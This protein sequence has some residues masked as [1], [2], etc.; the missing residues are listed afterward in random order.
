MRHRAR[1]RPVRSFVLLV[2]VALGALQAPARGGLVLVDVLDCSSSRSRVRHSVRFSLGSI[3]SETATVGRLTLPVA[4]VM[5]QPGGAFAARMGRASSG[6]ARRLLAI[7]L[8]TA[9]QHQGRRQAFAVYLGGV[10]AY[11]S[12][13][14]DPGAGVTRTCFVEAGDGS[15]VLDV[16]IVADRS[17]TAPL[18]VAMLR[19]YRDSP[20]EPAEDRDPVVRMGL[21]LLTSRGLGYSIDEAELRRIGALIP[22]SRYLTPQAA[23]LYNFCVRNPAQNAAEIR[24]LADLARHAGIPLR[25]AFQVHWSGIPAGVPD[26]AGGTFTDLPYQQI[27]YDPDEQ[28]EKPGLAALMGPA[29]DPHYGLTV[30]N[31]WGNTPWLT[32]NHPRLNQYRRL[33][34]KQAIGAW[35]AERDRLRAGG[36]QDLLPGELSTGDETVYWAKGVDD[37]GYTAFNGGKPRTHLMADF[38]P[39]TVAAAARDGVTLDPRHGL[40][41][42]QRMWLHQNL[43][44]WQQTLVN[45]IREGLPP[46]PVQLSEGEPAYA[47][48]LVARNVYTEPYAMPVYPMKG[49]NSLHPGLEVGYVLNGRSGGE[50][51][52]GAAML[53]WLIKERERGRIALPNL[54]CTGADDGQLVACL[55]A[56]YAYGARFVT[57]YNW[58]YRQNVSDLLA[59]FVRSVARPAGLAFE[60]GAPEPPRSEA[61]LLSRE[62]AAPPDAFGVN[63]VEVAV[64]P[65]RRKRMELRVSLREVGPDHPEAVSVTSSIA[66]RGPD[67]GQWVQVSLPCMFHQSPGRRYEVSAEALGEGGGT[68][69]A[70]QD[71]ALAVRLLADLAEERARSVA[72]E[73]RQDAIDVIESVA[74]RHRAYPPAEPVAAMLLDARRLLARG[75]VRE[76]YRAAIR[77]DQ[78][79]VPA[80]Y[81]VP[82]PGARL[83]PYDLAVECPLA[84][85]RAVVRDYTAG[86]ARVVIRSPRA[87][88]VAL[89]RGAV[90]TTA[91]VAPNIDVQLW[92]E[93]RPARAG[94]GGVASSGAHR[95]R[96]RRHARVRSTA[97]KQAER[98]SAQPSAPRLRR[99]AALRY[100]GRAKRP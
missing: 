7:T 16:R 37:S 2:L 19:I 9:P 61:A 10:E 31:R 67:A 80:A 64:R 38:N 63:R 90:R 91:T 92:V 8:A 69:E 87:Q 52:S 4:G 24:R 23:V 58:H 56:A 62:Y 88:V 76:A 40:D 43:A 81:E 74:K 98:R 48:D 11:R 44:W 20:G 34:L 68:V 17:T 26:G 51:W 32:M 42:T 47:E 39:F 65:G 29:Y 85:V 54:E 15:D 96:L 71:G 1:C 77:A 97:G 89:K 30:P 41:V 27:T 45:W 50:Y 13:E 36:L 86:L 75:A 3:R 94:A 33:R 14:T 35:Q 6:G 99:G 95:P 66:V 84:P 93:R 60:P 25:V 46:E 72:L 28:A 83:T 12:V 21:A 18:T 55:R 82:R 79:S 57:M 5:L 49:L 78:A 59:A 73:D 22:K 70:A 100:N 53:P